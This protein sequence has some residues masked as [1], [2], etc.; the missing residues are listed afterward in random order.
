MG[1]ITSFLTKEP[2][3]ALTFDDGPN[4][5]FTRPLL[6][7]LEKHKA[8]ATF[9]MVG[10]EAQKN[11]K[12]V[13]EVANEGHA[14]ANHSYSHPSFLRIKGQERRR[15]I[16]K[17]QKVLSPFGVKLFRPPHGHQNIASRLDALLLGYRV[18]AWSLDVEDWASQDVEE[19]VECLRSEIKPGSIVLLHDSLYIYKE[20]KLVDRNAVLEA[21]SKLFESSGSELYFVT[22]PDLLK[23]GIPV[24]ENWYRGEY[25][26]HSG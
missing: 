16:K 7:I 9:F 25:K 21:V 13:R 20:A 26:L 17:C 14:I 5:K 12:L 19:M 11:P 1:T 24:K 23:K 22:I 15:E 6:K 18:V 2:L 3:A 4:E 10:E 8:R